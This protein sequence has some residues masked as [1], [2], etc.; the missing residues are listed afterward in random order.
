MT[1]P[2]SDEPD[3]WLELAARIARLEDE[4]GLLTTLYRY[5]HTID[6]GPDEE[7]VDLFTEDG[8]W[9]S[10]PN[11]A[12]GPEA[13]R[14]TARGREEL[15]RFIAT[16][17]HAPVRWHKHFL[18][19]PV[20]TIDGD[21]AS[22][23]SYFVRLDRYDRGIYMRGFGR[24]LD[25]LVRCDDGRWRFTERVIESEAMELRGSDVVLPGGLT[26]PTN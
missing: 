22:V 1:P 16:H 23:T 5:G 25:R 20:V 19:E 9:D 8:V 4:R 7:W 15:R 3:R 24:Y 12:L 14:I 17:T 6:Y 11:E 21:V 2:A 26:T 18:A 10:V 13:K